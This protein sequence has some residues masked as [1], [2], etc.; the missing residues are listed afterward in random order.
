MKQFLKDSFKLL[1]VFAIV[2]WGASK[3]FPTSERY[4]EGYEAERYPRGGDKVTKLGVD[5][6][7]DD[8]ERKGGDSLFYYN[9]LKKY[10]WATYI[11]TISFIPYEDTFVLPTTHLDDWRYMKN[12]TMWRIKTLNKYLRLCS[13]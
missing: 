2:A 7:W 8:F 3:Q 6:V 4:L 12:L 1:V 13:S 5:R 9:E 11:S 10:T